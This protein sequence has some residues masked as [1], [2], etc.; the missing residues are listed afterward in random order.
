MSHLEFANG[1]TLDEASLLWTGVVQ[2]TLT[3]AHVLIDKCL[4][5]IQIGVSVLVE[6]IV[7]GW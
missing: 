5:R 6:A 7:D 4:V 3:V 1:V 2:A